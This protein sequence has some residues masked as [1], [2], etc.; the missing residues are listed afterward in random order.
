MRRSE[1]ARPVAE[2]P[3]ARPAGAPPV[4]PVARIEPEP[5]TSVPGLES[6]LEHDL[7]ERP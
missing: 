1:A 2:E 7:P 5:A 3:P 4:E 6:V